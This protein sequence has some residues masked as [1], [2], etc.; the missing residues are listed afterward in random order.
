MAVQKYRLYLKRISGVTTQQN[1][2]NVHFGGSDSFLMSPEGMGLNLS[3]GQLTP[4]ALAQLNFL[5]RMNSSNGIGLSNGL[6]P[7]LGQFLLQDLPGPHVNGMMKSSSSL[8]P[9]LPTGLHLD[10]LSDTTHHLPLINELDNIPSNSKAFPQMNGNCDLGVGSFGGTTG[11]LSNAGGDALVMHI[12]H[13]RAPQQG[14]GSPANLSQPRGGLGPLHLLANDINFGHV[15]PSSTILG[16]IGPG[17]GLP[18]INGSGGRDSSPSIGA[19]TSLSSALGASVHHAPLADEQPLLGNSAAG[20]FSM[21]VSVQSP[22]IGGGPGHS[23]VHEVLNQ[24]QSMWAYN[25]PNHLS[26]VQHRFSQGTS[27]AWLGYTENLVGDI[28][29]ALSS[30]ISPQ[31]ST[32]VQNYG[33]GL[34]DSELSGKFTPGWRNEGN[35]KV[36]HL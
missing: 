15:S 3:S 17:I 32:Q 11:N 27:P 26:Q 8:L 20:T 24:Q 33:G 4:Q 13:S 12:L 30:G 23:L 28:G 35:P 14:G 21:A 36:P 31:Y 10:Q 5:G 29:P 18:A 7:L 25:P 1:N 9:S 34:L 2:M 19:G 16:N 22:K 6:D